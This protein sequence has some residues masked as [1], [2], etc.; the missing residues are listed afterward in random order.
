MLNCHELPKRREFTMHFF[1]VLFDSGRNTKRSFGTNT[2]EQ[3]N[4]PI[5]LYNYEIS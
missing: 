1:G 2:S 5:E 4:D 3:H